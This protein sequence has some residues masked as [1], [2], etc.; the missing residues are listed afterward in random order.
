MA[1][2][3]SRKKGTNNRLSDAERYACVGPC[4]HSSRLPRPCVWDAW[5]RKTRWRA[6][7]TFCSVAHCCMC[8]NTGHSSAKCDET[9]E[10]TQTRLSDADRHA[11]VGPCMHTSRLPQPCVW[12]ARERKTRWRRHSRAAALFIVARATTPATAAPSVTTH[13]STHKQG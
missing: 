9:R 1:L 8:H 3:A 10:H 2:T 6:T 11:C 5:E 7:F 12:D 13:A 4:M